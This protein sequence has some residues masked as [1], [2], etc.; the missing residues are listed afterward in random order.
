LF[1]GKVWS[2]KPGTPEKLAAGF[3]AR[4]TIDLPKEIGGPKEAKAG[5]PEGRER[6]REKFVRGPPGINGR[7][8]FWG[9]PKRGGHPRRM[10][11]F[12]GRNPGP[13]EWGMVRWSPSVGSSKRLCPPE[14]RGT[15]R[16]PT[17]RA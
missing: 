11:L 15:E 9:G 3:K 10:W 17:S 13:L 8:V 4:A 16:T 2:D 5:S 1:G 12:Y 14:G 6:P 7:G